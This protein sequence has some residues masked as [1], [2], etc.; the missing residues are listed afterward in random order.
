MTS[1]CGS[2]LGST[3]VIICTECENYE[4]HVQNCHGQSILTT[5]EIAH[6]LLVAAGL[7]VTKYMATLKSLEWQRIE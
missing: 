3:M 2:G 4:T 5:G 7:E 1:L 6:R